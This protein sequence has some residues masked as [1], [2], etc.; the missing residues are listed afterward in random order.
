MRASKNS[1]FFL[2]VCLAMAISSCKSKSEEGDMA[3]GE[4][5]DMTP[6]AKVNDETLYRADLDP[7]LFQGELSSEDSA[8]L[9][10]IFIENWIKQ[11]LLFS[12]AENYVS[13]D[14]RIDKLVEDYRKSLVLQSYENMLLKERLDSA[15]TFENLKAYYDEHKD[16]FL[17]EE[18]IVR[19]VFVKAPKDHP[20]LDSI[21][22][23]IKLRDPLD[24]D[25]LMLFCNDPAN[26]VTHNV[27]ANVWLKFNFLV[28]KLPEQTLSS[29]YLTGTDYFETDSS[30]VYLLKILQYAPS[31]SQAP[32]DYVQKD[33]AEVL[34][35]RRRKELV[36]KTAQELYNE[37]KNRGKF[38]IFVK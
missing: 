33:I 13:S 16:K 14:D 9:T 35:H 10:S 20:K 29:S 8:R 24:Y 18:P 12:H 17:L 38:E 36:E 26:P 6:L 3:N 4:V 30:Y 25:R 28:A 2:F 15:I 34:L 21:R 11:Q 5:R 37:A 22:M 32:L 19:C 23:A 7:S 27:D 1:L 31:N